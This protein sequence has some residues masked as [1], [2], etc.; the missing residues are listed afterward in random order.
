M[1]VQPE[2]SITPSSA[3]NNEAVEQALS[4]INQRLTEVASHYDQRQVNEVDLIAIVRERLI[5]HG[6]GDRIAA[7]DNSRFIRD[8]ANV[9]SSAQQYHLNRWLTLQFMHSNKDTAVQRYALIY[10]INAIEWLK[11]FDRVILPA[12]IDFDLVVEI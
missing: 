4:S 1:Q 12:L 6:L 8:A 7:F 10:E 5:N 11:V 3:P 2:P 9:S